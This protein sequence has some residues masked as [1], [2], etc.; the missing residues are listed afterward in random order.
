MLLKDTLLYE[1]SGGWAE[2]SPSEHNEIFLL[3]YMQ[4]MHAQGVAFFP[5]LDL[6]QSLQANA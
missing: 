4:E 1:F 5:Q 3:E 6:T 2:I